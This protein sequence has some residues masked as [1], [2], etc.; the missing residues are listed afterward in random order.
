MPIP[1]A[2]LDNIDLVL[3][4]MIT[5]RGRSVLSV[6][7]EKPVLLV[8]LRHFGCTFCKEAVSDL[9]CK[10]DAY[11]DSGVILILVHMSP[12]EDAEI[13][14][15][16]Y[17]FVDVEHV[18]DPSCRF[19]AGFGL[20]K[21]NFSQLFGLRVMMRGFENTMVKGHS[22]GRFIGDGFQMPGVFLIQNG[23]VREKFVHKYA[24]DRPNYD[25]IVACCTLP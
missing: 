17:G 5:N 12:P 16:G 7:N 13:F 21:G 20:V 9:S 15:K 3:D 2:N 24:S 6:S 22:I 8:F 23:N 25:Q 19:Y 1:E 10:Q 18:S 14:F 4:Q 11:L